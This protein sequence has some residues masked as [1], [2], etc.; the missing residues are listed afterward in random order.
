MLNT[1]GGAGT[2]E[3]LD[4]AGIEKLAGGDRDKD[5]MIVLYAP[6]C[7]FCQ[8][9]EPTYTQV[10]SDIASSDLRVAKYQ[11]D[12]DR[13]YA[14]TLGLKTYPTLIFLPKNSDKV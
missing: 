11:A 14:E 7:Q 6:W 5:S 10:A 9:F 4:K 13:D 12:I 8:G 2:V 3:A 1:T